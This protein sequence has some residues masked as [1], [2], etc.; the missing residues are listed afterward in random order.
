MRSSIRAKLI[1]NNIYLISF[2]FT[3]ILTVVLLLSYRTNMKNLQETQKQIRSALIAKGQILVANNSI[4]MSGMVTDNA[5]TE[6]RKLVR[7]TVH[8]DSDI[9]YGIYMTKERAPYAVAGKD[10][11]F[12]KLLNSSSLEDSMSL[13]ASVLEAPDLKTMR[14][15]NEESY[16][17]ASPVLSIDENV[18]GYIRYA[19]TTKAMNVS[20]LNAKL[21][22][23]QSLIELLLLLGFVAIG[24]LTT[25]FYITKKQANKITTPI[26]SLAKSAQEIAGGNYSCEIKVESDDE[27]GLLSS[28]FDTMRST[29]KTFTENLQELVE[30]KM[31]QVRDIMN[32]IDQGLFTI[33]MDLSVNPEYSISSNTILGFPDIA[34]QSVNKLFRIREE[35]MGS[36]VDWLELV[37]NRHHN[38]RWIKLEK[39]APVRE[40]EIY[41]DGATT[42]RYVTVS[43]QK[44]LEKDGALSKIMVLVKD[45]TQ[46]RGIEKK[47][48]EERL[49]HENEVKTILGIVGNPPEAIDGF[50][51]VTDGRLKNLSSGIEEMLKNAVR[52]RAEFP[53]GFKVQFT[54]DEVFSLF[55]ELHTIKGDSGSFGFE[56]LATRAHE[57]EDLLE[58]LKDPANI[59][60]DDT[61]RSLKNNIAKMNE[62]LLYIK[63]NI[64]KLSG[65]Q[66][67]VV[68]HIVKSR[69]DYLQYA[70][71]EV[72]KEKDLPNSCYRLIDACLRVNYKTVL[73]LTKKYHDLVERTRE[74]VEKDVILEIENSSLEVHPHIFDDVD[75]ALI[76]ILRNAVDHGIEPISERDRLKK[77][78]GKINL[79]LRITEDKREFIVSDDGGG[80]NRDKVVTKALEKGLILEADAA[81]LTDNEKLKLIF[82][83]GFST[84]DQISS[85]S[86]RGVGMD[87]V[88]KVVEKLHGDIMIDSR[89]GFG[90]TFTISVPVLKS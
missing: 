44:I 1:R 50:M 43:Y 22:A 30:E 82:L 12:T 52:Q 77:G 68:L 40:L 59:R 10:S 78:P 63:E 56:L 46:S 61:L 4:A 36:M 47:M 13:W 80:I 73:Q 57:S 48:E 26:Q 6:I 88:A 25:A 24:A 37:K 7:T 89:V 83:P 45:I 84:A 28:A 49:R 23:R 20:I 34:V 29:V 90:T 85:I 16:E 72:A 2:V 15:N 3:L 18:M 71:M 19:F 64:R 86:G 35:E 74:K 58:L 75:E 27:I 81:K 9:V 14:Y 32:N 70:G 53:D 31:K 38:M 5:I 11:L 66:E 79:A 62:T 39:V 51:H 65:G 42:P 69:V 67:E 54:V 87:I 76:H 17:F 60:R 41:D 33:N 8:G 21:R 55:R